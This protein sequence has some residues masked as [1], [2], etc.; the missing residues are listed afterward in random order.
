MALPKNID[1][2]QA[3][4]AG[5]GILSIKIIAVAIIFLLTWWL[6]S[7]NEAGCVLV[8][9][10]ILFGALKKE[11]ISSESKVTST[12]DRLSNFLVP[13]SQSETLQQS[14]IPQDVFTRQRLQD[15]LSVQMKIQKD[16]LSAIR[17]QNTEIYRLEIV[18]LFIGTALWGFGDQIEGLCCLAC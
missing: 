10:A 5:V 2:K 4:L 8:L 16:L 11:I 13:R 12:L 17:A 15:D 7:L 3:V 6:S 9:L 18:I 1:V 14:E